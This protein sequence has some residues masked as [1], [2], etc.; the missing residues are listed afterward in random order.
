MACIIRLSGNSH[1]GLLNLEGQYYVDYTL[2][3]KPWLPSCPSPGPVLAL[4]SYRLHC[5]HYV[6]SVCTYARLSA[7]LYICYAC[8]ACFGHVHACYIS[9]RVLLYSGC[10]CVNCARAM[11][12]HFS[13]L[14]MHKLVEQPAKHFTRAT[15]LNCLFSCP[16]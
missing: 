7:M 13:Q 4:M 15:A 3:F 12:G 9:L 11:W 10:T 2:C 1:A 14:K 16:Y 8:Y 5:A 6:G